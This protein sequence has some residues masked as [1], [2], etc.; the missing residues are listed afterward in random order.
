MEWRWNILY[1]VDYD[2]LI[3]CSLNPCSNGMAL[4]HNFYN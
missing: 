2:S 3:I 1:Y 4:E